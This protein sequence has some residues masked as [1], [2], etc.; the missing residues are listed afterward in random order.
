MANN[1]ET[2]K[3]FSD[4]SG[5][6]AEKRQKI[7][8]IVAKMFKSYGFELAETPI[9]EFEEFVRGEN[10][11]DEAVSDVFKLE[12]KGKRKLALRYEFTFQLKRLAMNRK[13]PYKRYQIGYVFRDEPTTGNRFRQFTQCDA[14][15]V[16]ST[17]KEEA[18]LLKIAEE[19]FDRLGIKISI[20]INNRKLLNEILE[21][22]GVKKENIKD[23]IKEIDKLDKLSEKEVKENL[24]KYRA[25]KIIEIFKKNEK[26]FEK[27]ENYKEILELKKYCGLYGVKVNFSPSLARG[28]SYYNSS[29]FEVKTSE[30]KESVC[31]GGSFLVNGIQ[32][33]GISFGLERLSSLAKINIDEKKILIISLGKDKEAI[34]LASSLR[35]K[36]ISCVVMYGRVTK[37]LEYAN[38]YGIEKVIFI[39]EEE[40]KKKKIMLKDMKTGKEKFV[41]EKELINIL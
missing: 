36:E 23:V 5:E 7:K 4:Y 6:E 38:S 40:I 37:A 34:K 27:Y 35:E 3:G 12:D 33:T 16:G 18:E 31:G 13:L 19:V 41:S 14:D 39:G 28:L 30:M 15:I 21:K 17:F 11:G 1:I 24:K 25:E 20:N 10:A 9:V 32:S 22:E 26:Y 8:G 2:V 29:V